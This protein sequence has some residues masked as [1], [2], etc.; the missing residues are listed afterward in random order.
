M[1]EQSEPSAPQAPFGPVPPLSQNRGAAPPA[2]A[3]AIPLPGVSPVFTYVFLAAIVLVQIAT[4]ALGRLP[5]GSPLTAALGLQ[6]AVRVVAERYA[7]LPPGTPLLYAVGWKDTSQ[8]AAGEYWRLVTPLFLHGG[9]VHLFFNG[10]ALYIIGPQVE[11]LFGYLR[12]AAIYLLS[13]IAGVIASMAFNPNVPSVGASGAIFGLL[14][15]LMVYLYRNRSLLG[16]VGRRR[17]SAVL[18]VAVLN[19]LIGLAPNIDNWG[20]VG[21]LVGGAALTWLVGPLFVLH[22]EYDGSVHVDDRTSVAAHWLG[23]LVG[24][25]T[26]AALTTLVV[27]AY[28]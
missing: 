20:H 12:F 16:G 13:G 9:L 21:G 25:V 27:L 24:S 17:L 11:R 28:S 3:R 19:L 2:P 23:I 10:Y 26:L 5:N 8:I 1:T 18:Q 15:A 6:G 14:G 22:N 7:Y 4:F